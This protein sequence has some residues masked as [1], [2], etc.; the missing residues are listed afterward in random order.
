MSKSAVKAKE[1]ARREK[2]AAKKASRK[3]LLAVGIFALAALAVMAIIFLPGIIQKNSGHSH[4]EPEVYGQGRNSIELKEN[5][6]FSASLPHN[7]QKTGTYTK[8]TEGARTLVNFNVNGNIE[9]G[10]IEN[11]SLHLPREWDDGHGHGTVFPR[12][13]EAQ[14]QNHSGHSHDH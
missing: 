7:V 13:G 4:Y 12:R 6:N 14:S 2:K 1:K 3:K 5:G 8:T 9:V 10:R 11:N